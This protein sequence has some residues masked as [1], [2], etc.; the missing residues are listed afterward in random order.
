MIKNFD[1]NS[2]VFNFKNGDNISELFNYD[3]NK[4]DILNNK[5]VFKEIRFFILEKKLTL[6]I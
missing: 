4:K 5:K 3:N 1:D 2:E 6:K